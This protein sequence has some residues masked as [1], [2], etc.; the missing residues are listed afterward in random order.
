[1]R[2]TEAT[3]ERIIQRIR[4]LLLAFALVLQG[5]TASVASGL[6]AAPGHDGL[7]FLCGPG[8]EAP[9]R[10]DEGKSGA[11]CCVVC[12]G[13]TLSVLGGA[14]AATR[15]AGPVL[16]PLGPAAT[17]REPVE[18]AVIGLPPLGARAPPI[19]V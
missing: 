9:S 5:L 1:M 16:V 13:T 4:V 6:T 7:G 15:A 18:P 3:V 10:P 2:P 11:G 14:D 8:A 17:A 12:P 19:P